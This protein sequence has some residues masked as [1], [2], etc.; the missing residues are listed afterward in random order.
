[1]CDRGADF[2]VDLGLLW[3]PVPSHGFEIIYPFPVLT[4][5]TSH[6]IVL[7]AFLLSPRDSIACAFGIGAD[8][9]CYTQYESPMRNRNKIRRSSTFIYSGRRQRGRDMDKSLEVVEV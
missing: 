7:R 1:V 4:I 8:F 3:R 5:S 9:I 2:V 6:R